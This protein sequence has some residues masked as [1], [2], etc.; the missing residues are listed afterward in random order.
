MIAP[1]GTR[2]PMTRRHSRKAL[3]LGPLLSVA[4]GLGTLA[5]L[6]VPPW[7]APVAGRQLGYRASSMI[8]W[9]QTVPAAIALDKPAVMLPA[10]HFGVDAA[11]LNDARPATEVYKNLQV[12][13]DTTAGQFMA[14]QV[15]LTNWV[16]PKTGCAFC[17]AGPD[18]ASDA[19]P[20]KTAARTM[21]QMTRTLNADWRGHVGEAGVTCYTCHR[22]EN[23][24]PSTWYPR[25]VKQPRPFVAKQDDWLETATTVRDFFPDAGFSEYLLQNTPGRGQSYT[26]LPT[27]GPS[28]TIIVK[29]L[30]EVMMQMSDGIG[31]N[32]G[33]CHNSRAF[34]DWGQS[35]PARW[36]GLE[37]IHMTQA[38]NND[39]L[40]PLVPHIPQTREIQGNGRPPITPASESGPQPGNGLATCQTC[41]YENPKPLHGQNLLAPFPTLAGPSASNPGAKP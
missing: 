12:V 9:D 7:H 11:A 5:V 15:A 4:A 25:A 35:T 20:Q 10:D 8:Q 37:G 6:I 22:G 18:F 40:L 36:A 13:T 26:A 39:F 16:A 17:H 2:K 34:F 24:P 27:T 38:I 21:I 33:Y 1:P 29:R 32:C 41:H 23:V 28:D 30:Y 19:K 3:K 14:L 31:V